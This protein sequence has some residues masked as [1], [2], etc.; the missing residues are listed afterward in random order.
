MLSEVSVS[1][2]SPVAYQELRARLAKIHDLD[3]VKALLEWDARTTMPEGGANARVEQI[4]S[5]ERSRHE[6]FTE[7]DVG[8]L[9]EELVP[10]EESLPADSDEAALIRT[11]RRDYEKATR[12][13]PSLNAR[14]A[15]AEARG[16]YVWEKARERS[17]FSVLLP[18]LEQIVE[19]KREYI[20][21]FDADD[22]YDVLLDDFEPGL[23]T[24]EAARLL[25]G[26][27]AKVAPLIPDVS[28]REDPVDDSFLHKRFPVADQRLLAHALL[29]L[30]PAKPNT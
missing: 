13:P 27:K 8:R 26:L 12:V 24:V 23:T 5:V 21:C 9:L 11:A 20:A 10:Y 30:L 28:E 17:D 2:D 6:R 3:R 14:L 29:T 19:L 22:P 7:E 4:A 16:Q 25:G 15:R 18:S 1:P